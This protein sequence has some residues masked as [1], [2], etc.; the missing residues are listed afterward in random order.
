MNRYQVKWDHPDKDGT[1]NIID[2]IIYA[3]TYTLDNGDVLF[4][5][6]VQN[7]DGS[8]IQIPVRAFAKGVWLKIALTQEVSDGSE[9]GFTNRA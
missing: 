1:P 3:Y 6:I 5:D 7:A 9:D 4:I 8:A 2:E